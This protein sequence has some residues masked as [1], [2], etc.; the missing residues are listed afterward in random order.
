MF[1]MDAL[2]TRVRAR[3]EATG[4]NVRFVGD[5]GKP[6]EFSFATTEKAGKFRDALVREGRTVFP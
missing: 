1:D 6:N 5:D 3:R 2:A 4:G